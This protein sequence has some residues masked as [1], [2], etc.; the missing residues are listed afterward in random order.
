[1]YTLNVFDWT[2]SKGVYRVAL[3]VVENISGTDD[4]CSP[5]SDG[6][7]PDG[8]IGSLTLVKGFTLEKALDKYPAGTEIA[9]LEWG[10]PEVDDNGEL[11]GFTNVVRPVPA[12]N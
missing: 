1:M 7:R 6:S 2:N 9:G 12:V 5:Y 4:F 10:T 11:N 3:T 8:R